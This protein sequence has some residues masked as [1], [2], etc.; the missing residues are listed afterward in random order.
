MQKKIGL[1]Y[2]LF[3]WKVCRDMRMVHVTSDCTVISS[4][5]GIGVIMLVRMW[6][7]LETVSIQA[8]R[9]R[10][11]LINWQVIDNQTYWTLCWSIIISRLIT[12]LFPIKFKP[13]HPCQITHQTVTANLTWHLLNVW[14]LLW[15]LVLLNEIT[16]YKFHWNSASTEACC[17]GY[18]FCTCCCST[19]I[20]LPASSALIVSSVFKVEYY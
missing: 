1:G 9:V 13:F 4:W 12:F 10:G 20:L 17:G 16:K 19:S 11:V 6:F 7:P 18:L 14:L 5:D 8:V 3:L 2:I 15:L